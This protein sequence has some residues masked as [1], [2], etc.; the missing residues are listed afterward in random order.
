MRAVFAL[1]I[2]A[3]ALAAC[4]PSVAYTPTSSPKL[5]VAVRPAAQVDVVTSPPARPYEELG[6]FRVRTNQGTTAEAL[7][8]LRRSA[9]NRGCDAV[10]IVGAGDLGLDASNAFASRQGYVATCIA[11]VAAA[12]NSGDA[13]R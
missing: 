4:A 5:P 1:F 3:A 8:E 12:P 13:G 2:A 10:L 11:Y 6:L 9:G 7:A